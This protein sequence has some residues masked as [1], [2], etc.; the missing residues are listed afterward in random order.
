MFGHVHSSNMVSVGR[1][2]GQGPGDPGETLTATTWICDLGQSLSLLE[3]GHCHPNKKGAVTM[4][5][6]SLL[7]L[8]FTFTL[9]D[10][11]LVCN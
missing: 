4:R 2:L 10:N 9:L 11:M 1:Q 5:G 7:V 6:E 3:S 8:K